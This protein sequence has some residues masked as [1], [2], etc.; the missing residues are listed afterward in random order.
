[1]G[2]CNALLR[3]RRHKPWLHWYI[4]FVWQYSRRSWSGAE[5]SV[6]PLFPHHG[7][8]FHG[9]VIYPGD[10][11]ELLTRRESR[12]HVDWRHDGIAVRRVDGPMQIVSKR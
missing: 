5:R 3:P 4:E 10:V 8:D 1:M 9:V 6:E 7:L 2:T 11:S 12:R